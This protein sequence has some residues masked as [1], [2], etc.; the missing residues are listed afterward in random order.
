[1]IQLI[2]TDKILSQGTCYEV[3]LDGKVKAHLILEKDKS[4]LHL[5]ITGMIPVSDVKKIIEHI[6]RLKEHETI[7][8]FRR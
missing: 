5:H 7:N 3:V 1:M 8:H 4:E 6:D 2:A